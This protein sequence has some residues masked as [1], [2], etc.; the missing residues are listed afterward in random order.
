ML[1]NT[2]S[3]AQTVVG[4][5][6]Y[7]SPEIIQGRGYSFESDIWSLGVLLFE[8]CCLRPPFNAPNL[9]KLAGCI[10][11][12]PIPSLPATFSP[13]LTSLLKACL[14]R[15]QKSR[16]S[17]NQVLKHPL[18]SRRIKFY[19]ADDDFKDEFSHT[20]LHNKDAFQIYQDKKN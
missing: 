15:D 2:K 6:Y 11:N 16:P 1:S 13:A 7:L 5:P 10:L 9:H 18:L 12:D 8:L 14:Q 4:T 19:L 3:S 17:I 20:I